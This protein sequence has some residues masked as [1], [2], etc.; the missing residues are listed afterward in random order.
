LDQ[1]TQSLFCPSANLIAPYTNNANSAQ[2]EDV[3]LEMDAFGNQYLHLIL[4][5][6]RINF[7]NGGLH[8]PNSTFFN[9]DESD[10]VFSAG[11]GA[12]DAE[13]NPIMIEVG[14]KVFEVNRV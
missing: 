11:G 12:Y 13:G 8:N 9:T 4:P 5:A 3:S 14:C 1:H 2:P 10:F 7:L 6:D